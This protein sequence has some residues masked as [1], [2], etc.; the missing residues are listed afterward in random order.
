MP[1]TERVR[2]QQPRRRGEALGCCLWARLAKPHHCLVSSDSAPP[3]SLQGATAQHPVTVN[4]AAWYRNSTP[5]QSVGDQ[6]HSRALQQQYLSNSTTVTVPHGTTAAQL[7]GTQTHRLNLMQ[8]FAVRTQ[9]SSIT[10]ITHAPSPRQLPATSKV[11]SVFFCGRLAFE[12]P[13][14]SPPSL[15]VGR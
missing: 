6:S 14:A 8:N 2:A 5:W 1:A 11:C 4:H 12:R 13:S 9:L 3:L 10:A 15:R 7:G